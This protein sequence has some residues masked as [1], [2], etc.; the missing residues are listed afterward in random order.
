ML[1]ASSLGAIGWRGV[2]LAV[3]GGVQVVLLA[4]G[5][6]APVAMQLSVVVCAAAL[7]SLALLW[8]ALD[9]RLSRTPWW[10][11]FGLAL[12]LRLIAVQAEPLLEDDH[13]RYLW[14]GLRTAQHFD[15]Y[16]FAP[17]AFFAAPELSPLWHD[18]LSG[19]NNP[20]V[21]TIYGP[22]L[23]WLFALAHL[24]APGRVG[25]IQGLLLLVDLGC[26]ALL[27]QRGVGARWLLAY[28]V[29][30]VIL[31]EAMASAHPDGLVALWLLLALLTWQRGRMHWTGALLGLAVATKVAALVALP[32]FFFAPRRGRPS[33]RSSGA[34]ALGFVAALGL[35]YGPFVAFSGSDFV[36]LSTFAAHW[37]FN[38]LL[39]RVVEAGVPSGMA[40]PV[41]LVLIA[42]GVT[43]V[44]WHWRAQSGEGD[45]F[46]LPPVDSV[47]LVLILLAPVVNP[48]YAL[49]ALA[50]AIAARRPLVAVMG[51]VGV[52]AYFN[53]S[54]LHEAGWVAEAGR[55]APFAVAW[56]IALVQLAALACAA[57][58]TA[59]TRRSHAPPARSNP[60]ASKRH[61]A[62]DEQDRAGGPADR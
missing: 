45:N 58:W 10:W 43:A 27:A 4:A 36:G 54:V 24:L 47:L 35:A 46:A 37:R 3:L 32:L 55:A 28:A 2:A 17:S 31:K 61:G 21:A 29:H 11:I 1:A 57:V 5:S 15:P 25:A 48:W 13:Y 9:G 12:A 26:M 8:I 18:V 56:P 30:P 16:R 42:V 7:G 19:I 52:L 23:Q 41:A 34:L 60:R 50:P 39:Y 44:V 33:W 62:P 22:V 59:A 53:G 14:D 6:G 38:P 20:G 40:R 49:W 51:C